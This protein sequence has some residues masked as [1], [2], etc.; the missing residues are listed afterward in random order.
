VRRFLGSFPASGPVIIEG[1]APEPA[2]ELLHPVT[3]VRCLASLSIRHH[4]ALALLLVGAKL[5][6]YWLAAHTHGGLPAAMCRWD[7]DWYISVAIDGYDAK[8]HVDGDQANWAF[9]PLYPLA[10]RAMRLLLPQPVL[11]GIATSVLA[12]AGFALLSSA[13]LRE[14][15]QHSDPWLWIFFILT[16]PFSL[17]FYIPYSESLY[18]LLATA[19]LFVLHQRRP[20]G[21]GILLG[22]FTAARPTAILLV[23]VLVMERLRHAATGFRPGLTRGQ[24]IV[25]LADAA[26]PVALA[27]LGLFAFMALLWYRMGDPLA[28]SHVQAAWDRHLRDPLSQ[29][30][31][32]L[33]ACDWKRLFDQGRQSSSYGASF[34]LLGFIL[35]GWLFWQRRLIEAWFSLATLLLCLSTGFEALPRYLFGNPANLF[36]MFDLLERLRPKPL[37]WLVL[38]AMAVLQAVLLLAWFRHV[39]FLI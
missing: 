16:L 7:C 18:L 9:F 36:A 30:W 2:H 35:A 17:Y 1:T 8:P 20:L 5:G 29:I 38:A 33:L 34:A 6:L 24:R 32:G 39:D 10:V 37:R 26:L 14:T 23:P 12:F 21:S 3:P 25:I 22:I 31:S 27:P 19:S 28:F 11:A 15:R 4:A 13:Y